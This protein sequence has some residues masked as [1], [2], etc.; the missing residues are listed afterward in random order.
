MKSNKIYT[1]GYQDMSIERFV[2]VIKQHYIQAIIDIR[3]NPYSR[4]KHFS[5]KNLAVT[6]DT[7]GIGYYHFKELAAL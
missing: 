4:N 7:N 1:I 6:L 2:D 5:K 3:E